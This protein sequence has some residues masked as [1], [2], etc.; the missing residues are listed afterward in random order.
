MFFFEWNE[1][2]ILV[3]PIRTRS[4]QLAA[5][6]GSPNRCVGKTTSLKQTTLGGHDFLTLRRRAMRAFQ[7]V[8]LS[9]YRRTR[10]V[11]FAEKR[12]CTCIA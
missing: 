5:L 8:A 10:N 6:I 12:N 1:Q 4:E 3:N 2:S 9:D 11:E 7:I